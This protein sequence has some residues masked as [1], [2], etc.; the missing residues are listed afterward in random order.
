MKVAG[1]LK[2]TIV[3]ALWNFF[4]KNSFCFIEEYIYQY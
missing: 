1:L 2:K 4:L 3:F